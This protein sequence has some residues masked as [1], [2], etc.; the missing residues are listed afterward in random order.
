MPVPTNLQFGVHTWRAVRLPAAGVDGCD[1]LRQHEVAADLPDTLPR[2]THQGDHVSRETV[3]ELPTIR[4][5]HLA[6]LER[7]R[8][9]HRGDPSYRV[10]PTLARLCRG[11]DAHLGLQSLAP[12]HL[13]CGP[14]EPSVGVTIKG[15]MTIR[16]GSDPPTPGVLPRN[17]PALPR[18]RPPHRSRGRRGPPWLARRLARGQRA[19]GDRHCPEAGPRRE[20]RAS[21]IP[22]VVHIPR[23]Y[24]A[25]SH[26]GPC[27]IQ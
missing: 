6:P 20:G 17:R 5:S 16:S 4:S 8:T 26:V 3:G 1:G 25:P 22:E 24:R 19:D 27:R 14:K 15:T 2:R 13:L 9:P 18:G 21:R 12:A 23:H 7:R 10:R 11:F